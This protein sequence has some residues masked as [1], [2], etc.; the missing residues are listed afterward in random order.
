MTKTVW[1]LII[2]AYLDLPADRQDLVF[3]NWNL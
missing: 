3:G 2:G 1:N